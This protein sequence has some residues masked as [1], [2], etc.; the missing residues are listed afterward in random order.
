[1]SVTFY[2]NAEELNSKTSNKKIKNWDPN[3]TL[4]ETGGLTLSIFLHG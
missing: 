4:N 1:M 2:W 3:E